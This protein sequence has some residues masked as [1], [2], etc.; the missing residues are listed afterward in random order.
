MTRV[1]DSDRF[2]GDWQ[3]H[4]CTMAVSDAPSYPPVVQRRCFPEVCCVMHVLMRSLAHTAA[5]LCGESEKCCVQ[6]QRTC[7]GMSPPSVRQPFV[8]TVGELC[9]QKR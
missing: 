3:E 2:V 7:H 9:Y 5:F 6:A 4:F 8:V 1:I